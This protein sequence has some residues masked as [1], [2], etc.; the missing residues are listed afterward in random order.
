MDALTYF[1]QDHHTILLSLRLFILRF[2]TFII[3]RVQHIFSPSALS[4]RG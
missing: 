2:S 3:S 4:V 1:S